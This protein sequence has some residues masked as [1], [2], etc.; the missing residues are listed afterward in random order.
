MRAHSV[1]RLGLVAALLSSVPAF[2]QTAESYQAALAAAQAANGKAGKL[3][4]QWTV[5]SA[6]MAAAKKAAD[7]GDYAT[8]EKLAKQAQAYAEASIAQSESEKHLWKDAEV[9]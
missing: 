9:R 2:G 1:L 5:T 7:A 8:A 4:N 6:A 3:R